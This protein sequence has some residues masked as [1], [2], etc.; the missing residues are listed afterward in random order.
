MLRLVRWS[1]DHRRMVVV[2]WVVALIAAMGI[3]RAV[4]SH[5]AAGFTLPGTDSQRA[6]DLLASHFPAQSGDSD[7]I[8]LH[9]TNGKLTAP[10]T[11][12]RIDLML[13]KVARL[14]HVTSVSSPFSE[15]GKGLS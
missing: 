1:S 2:V 13:S 6:A 12:A 3:S 9:T 10:A 5:Y 15:G 14:P 4:G 8:V 11:R 7:Q